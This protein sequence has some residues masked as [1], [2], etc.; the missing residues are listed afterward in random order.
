MME[1]KSWN[2][3]FLESIGIKFELHQKKHTYYS[4]TYEKIM[5]LVETGVLVRFSMLVCLYAQ[6]LLKGR[7]VLVISDTQTS[8]DY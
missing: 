5:I 2:S 1:S 6:Q 4:N 8:Q 3:N 7:S